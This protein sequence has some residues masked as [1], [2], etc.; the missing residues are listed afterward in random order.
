VKLDPH[1]VAASSEE[2]WL[3]LANERSERGDFE[4]ACRAFRDALERPA[5]RNGE[6]FWIRLAGLYRDA[7][8]YAGEKQV[9]LAA[10]R[11]HPEDGWK[12][13]PR[14]AYC[15]EKL[16]DWKAELTTN[17][18][19]IHADPEYQNKYLINIRVMADGKN[20]KQQYEEACKI[21]ISALDQTG[22]GVNQFKHMLADN[23]LEWGKC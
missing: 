9:Y 10:L 21:Q 22:L 11:K 23:Y 20:T 12:Y 15:D 18:E 13:W 16:E 6:A 4:G 1:P 19:A 8:D 7:K 2:Y 14:V 3:L 5:E 17:L